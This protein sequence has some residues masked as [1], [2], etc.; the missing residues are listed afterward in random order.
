MLRPRV[1]VPIHW[2]TYNPLAWGAARIEAAAT[3]PEEFRTLAAA[4]APEVEVCVL[5][6]NGV[7][8]LD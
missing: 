7:L 3:A 5:G 6:R 1:C 2:G 4:T 8:G